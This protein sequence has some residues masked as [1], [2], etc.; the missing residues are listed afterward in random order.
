MSETPLTHALG[1][2]TVCNP[3]S[4]SSADSNPETRPASE[5]GA[6]ASLPP[7]LN[8]YSPFA[9]AV[10]EQTTFPHNPLCVHCSGRLGAE[11]ARWG[12]GLCDGCYNACQKECH[13]CCKR[14]GL[15]HHYLRSGLCDK[16]FSSCEKDCRKCAGPLRLHELHWG[17]ALCDTCYHGLPKSCSQCDRRLATRELRWGTGL[18]NLCY[19]GSRPAGG[20]RCHACAR[21]LDAKTPTAGLQWCA[22]VQLSTLC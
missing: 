21:P 4:Y 18:C 20:Y 11:E 9:G 17:S 1:T 6:A 15:K 14:L 7:R 8:L 2:C 12:S 22:L 19:D 5:W 10:S 3:D 13:V 16:C